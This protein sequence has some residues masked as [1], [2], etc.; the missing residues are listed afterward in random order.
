MTNNILCIIVLY[1]CKLEES[2]TYKS[3]YKCLNNTQLKL[4]LLI[5]DN[6]PIKQSISNDTNPFNIK[7]ICYQNNNGISLAY[8]YGYE[9]AVYLSKK[10]L[11]LMD[12]DTYF[13]INYFDKL[14][15]EIT[16]NTNIKIFA[17]I[18][19][20]NNNKILSPC[21]YIF[22]KGFLLKKI[23]PGIYSLKKLS[24]INSGLLIELDLYLK[25]GKYNENLFLDYCDFDFIN[26]VAMIENKFMLIDLI[27]TQNFSNDETDK[28]KLKIR[29]KIFCKD[30]KNCTNYYFWDKYL[31]FLVL[32]TRGIKL[33]IRTKDTS[34]L[35]ILYLTY[36]KND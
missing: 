27:C 26:K 31:F 29:Y 1:K 11:L 13:P 4:D 14:N 28:D 2:I 18:V 36:N 5:Y 23:K 15:E 25:A 8:N 17:P 33:T 6:S 10:W 20:T 32:L 3:L 24:P 35:K 7:Y 22:K 19:I 34:F 16:N 12:Q 21:K 9:Y 30:L